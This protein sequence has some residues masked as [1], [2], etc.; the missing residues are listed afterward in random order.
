MVCFALHAQ[1]IQVKNAPSVS[2]RQT[3][4]IWIKIELYPSA[5]GHKFEFAEHGLIFLDPWISDFSFSA[6]SLRSWVTVPQRG[7]TEMDREPFLSGALSDAALL[8]GQLL[9]MWNQEFCLVIFSKHTV[10]Q[11]RRW[12][13]QCPFVFRSFVKCNLFENRWISWLNKCR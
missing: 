11:G 6:L 2:A 7:L 3:V 10:S 4:H 12:C 8:K 1:G 5:A 13:F 9:K